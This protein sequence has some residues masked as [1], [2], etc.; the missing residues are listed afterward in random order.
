MINQIIG[1]FLIYLQIGKVTDNQAIR[2]ILLLYL[3]F[4]AAKN[5]SKSKRKFDYSKINKIVPLFILMICI[6][7]LRSSGIAAT[8]QNIF[9][10][11]FAYIIYTYFSITT[12]V[13]IVFVENSNA[14]SILLK[15]I[16]YPMGLLVIVNFSLWLAN[17][18]FTELQVV[19]EGGKAVMLSSLGID[20]DRVFFPLSGGGLN[21]FSDL[22]GAFLVF[23]ITILIYK[24]LAFKF[25]LITFVTLA[26][27]LM[28]DSRSFLI[29]AV[30]AVIIVFALGKFR[31][32]NILKFSPIILIISPFFLLT[33]LPIFY[34]SLAINFLRDTESKDSSDRLIIWG[35]TIIEISNFKIQHIFGYGE[36][37]HFASGASKQ[38]AYLFSSWTNPDYVGSHN[39]FFS[40]VFDYGYIGVIIYFLLILRSIKSAL[41]IWANDQKIFATAILAF[42]VYY[43]FSGATET[44]SG[45][46]SPG[47]L[48]IFQSTLIACEIY[49]I[50]LT[51][52]NSGVIPQG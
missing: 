43:L 9:Y 8:A 22:L 18:R 16:I 7:I 46:Y 14:F 15:T 29:N 45:E 17:I 10:S 21:T 24:K 12:I 11:L 25:L 3:F 26:T 48:Y 33:Y 23:C 38:W 47:M 32:L 51:D 2:F 37:G 49:R 44:L 36:F 27:M 39:T 1:F 34:K 41:V 40:I 42:W 13:K 50:Y 31:K 30:I 19:E 6:G 4:N 35:K 20:M 52:R 28:I 5:Y